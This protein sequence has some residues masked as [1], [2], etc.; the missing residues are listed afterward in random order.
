MGQTCNVSNS[1]SYVAPT[2]SGANG[3]SNGGGNSQ[4]LRNTLQSAIPSDAVVLSSAAFQRQPA[5]GISSLSP[6]ASQGNSFQTPGIPGNAAPPPGASS[7]DLA[8]ATPD[9]L[10]TLASQAQT[11]QQHASVYT[12]APNYQGNLNVLA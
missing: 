7:G 8:N 6:P 9:Q 3:N 12:P 11:L 1:T 4:G 2:L 10:S 5:D